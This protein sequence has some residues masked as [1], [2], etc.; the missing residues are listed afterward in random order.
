M[1]I[2]LKRTAYYLPPRTEK[3]SDLKK[4]NPDW[5]IEDIEKK[6]GILIRHI[7]E[8]NQTAA[9][10]GVL[11]AQKLFLSGV[12]KNEIDFLIL[13]TQSPDYVLPTTA[14][15]LQDRLGI[16]KSCMAFDINLGCS[17][18]IYGLAVGGSLIEAGLAKQGLLIC[19]ET[20]TKYI[21]KSDR[22]CRPLFSDGAS[23]T[24]LTSNLRDTLGPFEMGTD[25]SGYQNLIVPLSGARMAKDNNQKRQ[26]FMD[27]AEILMFTMDAVPKCVNDLLNKSGKNIND[28]DLFVFHQGSKLVMDNIIRRL[29]LPA[30]KVFINCQ[31]VGNTVSASI[32]IA[33]KD[34]VDQKRLKKGDLVMLVGFGVGLSWGACL[35]EWEEEE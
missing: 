34:A 35:V 19:S 13:V 30:E 17:G 2:T 22:T 12:S 33:L 7:T 9:D 21:D 26:L 32:P 24:L 10:M 1:K 14:C 29:D 16:K 20:Y 23:A 15:I 18:F 5:R 25:G 28:I 31:E 11:A 4:D 8:Q 3:G 6:T 27:G